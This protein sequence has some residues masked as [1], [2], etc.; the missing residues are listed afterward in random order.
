MRN[1]HQS[2]GLLAVNSKLLPFHQ[3]LAILLWTS[4]WALG[5]A[6]LALAKLSPM[7]L[8]PRPAIARELT[9]W[10]IRICSRVCSRIGLGLRPVLDNYWDALGGSRFPITLSHLSRLIGVIEPMFYFS[11][12]PDFLVTV[13]PLSHGGSCL[14]SS[15]S[16]REA[17]A[18]TTA[19]HRH[20]CSRLDL[21]VLDR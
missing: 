14:P 1:E 15:L 2:T 9:R 18:L 6:G 17:I 11:L 16:R 13:F 21:R 5:L 7:A 10:R 20:A 12:S 8:V 3:G 4:D 19:D